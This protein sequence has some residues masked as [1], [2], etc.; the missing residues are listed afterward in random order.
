MSMSFFRS[1]SAQVLRRRSL[2]P[3]QQLRSLTTHTL[4]TGAKIPAIG[5]GTFQ[6][7]D[8]QEGAVKMALQCGYRHID[9][10]RV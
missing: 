3:R 7:A 5:F 9:T 2:A 1:V 6:D 8:A 4:N 10:A